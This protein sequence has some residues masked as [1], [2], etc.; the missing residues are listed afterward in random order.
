MA[1]LHTPSRRSLLVG[2]A[3]VAA[4]A[5]LG[6]PTRA[7][8]SSRPTRLV[9]VFVGGGWD[10]TMSTAPRLDDPYVDGPRVDEDPAN[11]DDV[12]Y[13]R[14]FGDIELACNDVKRPAAASFFERWSSL[15]TVVH[16]VFTGAVGHETSTVRMMTGT[17]SNT[18]PD[19][20]AIMGRA[21]G[22]DSPLGYV[23]LAGTPF[24]GDYAASSGRLGFNSQLKMLFD[25]SS[26]FAPAVG[27]M[28]FPLSTLDDADRDAVQRFVEARAARMHDLR[29]YDAQVARALGDLDESF[30]RSERFRAAA[31]DLVE[32]LTLGQQ[33]T[34]ERQGTLAA[35]L[36]AR[37]VCR[38]VLIDSNG[39]WDTHSDNVVQH[40][41]YE[42]LFV[43]LDHLMA[44][45]D[46]RGLL[47]STLVVVVSE[48][49][50]APRLNAT[51]GKDHWPHAS[52]MLLGAG[53]RGQAS[54]GGYDDLMESVVQDFDTGEVGG[55]QM[56]RHDHLIAGLLEHLD[57]DPARY[58]PEATPYRG[59]VA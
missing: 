36:L 13:V 31:G 18:S 2:G 46:L 8:A 55:G 23:A 47:S 40:G 34:F 52:V 57:I 16:G 5:A 28:G 50:R 24:V 3:A 43:G 44:E 6:R 10:I 14:T 12:E 22:A 39:G 33:P 25:P 51:A 49:T 21:F 30:D 58:L 27:D 17:P 7:I 41:N 26:A 20:G 37:D 15:A 29:G 59:F 38:S 35:D 1:R 11:P 48:M 42:S 19:L 56:L 53:V 32:S 9:T 45:L 54:L 4:A